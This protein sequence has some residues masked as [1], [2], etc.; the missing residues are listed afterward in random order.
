MSKPRRKRRD[1]DQVYD[2]EWQEVGSDGTFTGAFCAEPGIDAPKRI[3]E[4]LF[5]TVRL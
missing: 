1:I 3:P 4:C 2:G 5:V